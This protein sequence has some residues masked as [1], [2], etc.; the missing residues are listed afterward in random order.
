MVNILDNLKAIFN[1]RREQRY[2]VENGT[3]VVISNSVGAGSKERKVELID[4]SHGGMAFIYKGSPADLEKSGIMKVIN[5]G[6][7]KTEHISFETISDIPIE[8]NEPHK[9]P[10]RRRGVKFTWMGFCE[11]SG[12]GLRDLINKIKLCEK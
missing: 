6:S 1:A 3:F 7:H 8:G 12:L 11:G 4:I 2:F 5:E 9:E 10:I